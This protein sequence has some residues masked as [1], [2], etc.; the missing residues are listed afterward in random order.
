MHIFIWGLY[1]KEVMKNIFN[2]PFK[3]FEDMGFIKRTKDLEYVEFNRNIWNKMTKE[4]IKLIL[5]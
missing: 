3:R 2:N 5:N 1:K 4:K